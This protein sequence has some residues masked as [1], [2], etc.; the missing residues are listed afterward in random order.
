MAKSKDSL[1]GSSHRRSNHAKDEF[2]SVTVRKNDL[3]EKAGIKLHLEENGRVHIQAIAKNGIF[4]ESEVE[5]GDIVL[6]IN[7]KRLQIGEGPEILMNVINVAKNTVTVVVKKPHIAPRKSIEIIESGSEHDNNQRSSKS[8]KGN[9]AKHNVDGSLDYKCTTEGKKDPNAPLDQMTISAVKEFRERDVGLVFSV[10]DK[11][12]FITEITVDSIFK[13]TMLEVG[14]RVVSVNDMNFRSY[15]DAVYADRILRKADSVITILVEKD[16]NSIKKKKSKK[17]GA[18]KR[19]SSKIKA[20]RSSKSQSVSDEEST[21]CAAN[22]F[23]EDNALSLPNGEKQCTEQIISAPKDFEKQEVG[24]TLEERDNMLFVYQI[25]KKS[26]FR[27]SALTEG[28]RIISINDESFRHKSNATLAKLL[29]QKSR[30]AVSLIVEKGQSIF[31]AKTFDLDA[32]ATNL[33]W[34]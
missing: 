6:S 12:M 32:S 9:K 23:G 22:S 5:V 14:D 16:H 4:N 18:K 29:M 20:K 2:L 7:G 28:D 21:A 31:E 25:K 24:I 27:G 17:D 26:I 13:G 19:T 3:N 10:K 34:S 1:G 8:Y 30:E 33:V 15:A 11:M